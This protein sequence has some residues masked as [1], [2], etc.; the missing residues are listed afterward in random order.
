MMQIGMSPYNTLANVGGAYQGMEQ[1]GINEAMARHDF[2]QEEPWMRAQREAGLYHPLAAPYAAK[3]GSVTDSPSTLGKISQIGGLA[4]SI[5]GMGFGGFGGTP[6]PSGF[7]A[8]PA[9]NAYMGGYGTNPG[10]QQSQM[11]ASQMF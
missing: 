8:M 6:Q 10:S 5:G 7:G 11:L 9:M 1:K 3:E 4:S 2:A